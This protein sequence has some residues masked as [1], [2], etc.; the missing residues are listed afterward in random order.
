[1]TRLL[2]VAGLY[3]I[4]WGIAVVF[5]P[6]FVCRLLGLHGINY[7][8]VWQYVGVLIGLYGFAYIVAAS[9]PLRH[10]PVVLVG[11]L[12]K[13]AGPIGFFRAAI[14]GRLP[15]QFGLTVVVNDLVWWVPFC[16]ILARAYDHY[17]SSLRV[18]S[19]EVQDFALRAATNSGVSL[20]ELSKRQPV[21]LYFLRHAGCSFCRESLARLARESARLEAS[22]TGLALVHMDSDEHARKFLKR[23][24]LEHVPRVSDPKRA[25]YRAFGLSRGTLW[26]IMGPHLWLRGIA[27]ILKYG[28][29]LSPQGGDIFQM[30]GVFLLY[31][32]HVIRSFVHQ[33]AADR[34]DFVLLAQG[35]SLAGNYGG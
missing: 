7:P 6:S 18:V 25:L 1:M 9:A 28:Q 26:Q 3:S 14:E 34:P 10:W 8:E 35:G 24:G 4:C 15:W 2:W 16:I 23:Y 29:S 30:P 5:W 21:L 20:L 19:P 27:S 17:L 13:I 11:L 12:A 32:G 22:G 31:H 33:T